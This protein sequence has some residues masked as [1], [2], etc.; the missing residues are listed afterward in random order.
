MDLSGRVDSLKLAKL[1]LG[2]LPI[3][4]YTLDFL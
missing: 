4:G 2:A 3:G 1:I